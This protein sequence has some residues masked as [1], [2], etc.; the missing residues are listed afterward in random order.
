MNAP[1]LGFLGSQ[2]GIENQQETLSDAPLPY[3]IRDGSNQI[4]HPPMTRFLPDP[5]ENEDQKVSFAD[6]APHLDHSKDKFQP[7]MLPNEAFG[8]NQREKNEQAPSLHGTM[9]TNENGDEN[10]NQRPALPAA[11]LPLNQSGQVVQ[12]Y[13]P[14]GNRN[15]PN[16]RENLTE[17]DFSLP[18]K[19]ESNERKKE[20][21][22]QLPPVSPLQLNPFGAS[23]PQAGTGVP[24][25]SN[26]ASKRTLSSSSMGVKP[27]KSGNANQR[28]SSASKGSL[29]NQAK[30]GNKERNGNI[31]PV[32]GLQDN[33]SASLPHSIRKS[34]GS[35]LPEKK[36]RQNSIGNFPSKRNL[37]GISEN[38][39]KRKGSS[40]LQKLSAYPFAP[41]GSWDDH[42][43]DE[44]E[45][46][47]PYTQE[48]SPYSPGFTIPIPARNPGGLFLLKV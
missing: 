40:G 38:N 45:D 29:P 42:D 26:E 5:I 47:K 11:L 17:Q 32:S 9:Q 19:T 2:S 14:L 18:T 48:N 7:S 31:A 22:R 6:T 35:S 23:N 4:P 24:A 37:G 16:Q 1:R 34:R 13:S 41:V 33:L 46:P 43:L 27:S 15:L 10:E 20:S 28:I 8:Q 30:S 44:I 36:A 3:Y 39:M 25:N 21:Q 12:P